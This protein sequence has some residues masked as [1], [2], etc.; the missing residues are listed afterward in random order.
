M[1]G[2]AS[3]SNLTMC[4]GYWGAVRPAIQKRTGHQLGETRTRYILLAPGAL[5]VS[6][7]GGFQNIMIPICFCLLNPMQLSLVASSDLESQS[8]ENSETHGCILAKL[9]QKQMN[10]LP[11][12]NQ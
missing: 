12:Q 8:E 6:H 1:V 4:L 7:Q 3:A 9:M 5:T 2:L 10:T 11:F